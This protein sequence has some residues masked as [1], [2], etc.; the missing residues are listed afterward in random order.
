MVNLHKFFAINVIP[1]DRF[2]YGSSL[3]FIVYDKSVSVYYR[4]A[5]GGVAGGG[6]GASEVGAHSRHE[7]DSR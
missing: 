5:R 4:S 2:H 3:K 7:D 1:L 6:L